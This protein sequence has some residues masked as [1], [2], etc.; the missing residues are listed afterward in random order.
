MV[1]GQKKQKKVERESPNRLEEGDAWV[2]TCIKRRTY[3][4][5][6]FSVGK[7]TQ[8]TCEEMICQMYRR[9]RLP[10]PES[11]IEMF[12]DGNDDY[13]YVLAKYYAETCINYGQLLKIKDKHGR[14]IRKE[15]RTIYGNP[16]H[17]DIETTDVENFNGI[18]RERVGRLVRKTKCHSKYRRRLTCALNVFQFYWNFINVFEKKRSPAMLEGISDSLWDWHDF[19]T[20]NYAA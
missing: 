7:W 20:Y 4:L 12:T 2:Y 11:K 6:A 5:T 3:F 16:D 17:T 18:L 14:L 1:D 15:K 8:K 10:F 13:S 9:T 19:L